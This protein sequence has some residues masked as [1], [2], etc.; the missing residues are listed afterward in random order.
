MRGMIITQWCQERIRQ[1]I[2]KPVER[3]ID[4]TA[5]TGRDTLFLCSLLEKE[6]G[7]EIVAMDIQK[8]AL[9]K[10]KIRL[11]KEGY[12][13]LN[14]CC[15]RDRKRVHLV[16]DGHEHIDRYA[17]KNSVDFIMF[18]LGYLPGGNHSLATRPDTTLQALEKSLGLLKKE[19]MISLMIYSGGDTGF[20]EKK[21]VLEWLKKVDSHQYM[22]LVESFY[23]R[24]N[25]PPLPV[26]IKKIV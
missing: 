23:N 12:H 5:G 16:L 7:G 9:E 18:N 17:K 6:R 10:T 8:M 3:C 13:Y 19:G 11:Q 22:V 2:Q 1:M 21:Q 4:A 24:P 20:E 26:F 25:H 14:N 15:E